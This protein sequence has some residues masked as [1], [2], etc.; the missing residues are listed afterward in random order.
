MELVH[1]LNRGVDKR[2]IFLD[3]QD[4]FR[5]IHNLFEFNNQKGINN[6]YYRF[7]KAKSKDF[8]SHYIEREPRKLLVDIHAFCLMPNHYHL[9]LSSRVENGI[10]KFMTKLNIGYAKYFNEKYQRSGALFEGRYKSVLIKD[11]SH[12]IHIPYYIHCNPLDL[13][14]PQWRERE[15][16]AS[17]SAL[18][19]LD[20]Y[21]WS[22]HMDYTGQHNFPSVTNRKLLLKFFGGQEEYGR[23]LKEWLKSMEVESMKD[24]LLE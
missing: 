10:S 9:L 22:R 24:L 16:K 23:S 19:F 5:F 20:N 13:K 1:T 12:F 2:I 17:Q 4:R 14:Y 6:L 15:L 8:V 11:E 21:R 18:N 7:H 3:D